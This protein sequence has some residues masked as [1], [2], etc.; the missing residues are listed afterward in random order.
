MT[1]PL[2]HI[3]TDTSLSLRLNE[4]RVL[5]LYNCIAVVLPLLTCFSRF[6]KFVCRH[7][8]SLCT[9]LLI[10]NIGMLHEGMLAIYPLDYPFVGGLFS[11]RGVHR[12][13]LEMTLMPI[14]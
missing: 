13:S 10:S 6:C 5:D 14:L 11:G 2:V 3:Y 9:N 1:Y 4:V 12:P 8:D 7:S